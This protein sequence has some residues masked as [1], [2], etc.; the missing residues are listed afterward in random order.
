M[1]WF[2]GSNHMNVGYASEDPIQ[3]RLTVQG[4]DSAGVFKSTIYINALTAATQS[5]PTP[6]TT[7][8]PTLSGPRRSSGSTW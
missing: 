3:C 6:S 2:E 4:L 5:A 1:P 8:P 7:T